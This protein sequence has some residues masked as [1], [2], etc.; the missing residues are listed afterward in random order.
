MI[1]LLRRRPGPR[2]GQA[3][4][5]YDL[6]R[7][8]CPTVCADGIAGGNRSQYTIEVLEMSE[9][10]YRPVNPDKPPYRIPPMAEIEAVPW[11]GYK[12][13]STFSGCG[14]SCLGYRWAGFR[15]VWASEF[16]EAACD[17]Y[18]LNYPDVPVDPRDIREVR[19][20]EIF[21]AT[22]LEVGEI[23][24]LEGSPPCA[25]FSTAGKKEKLWGQ[26]RPY[27]ETK[28]RTDDLFFEFI[29]L[30]EGLKPRVF[31]AENVS[32]L[33]KGTAKGYFLEILAGLKACGYRVSA[34]LLDAQWLGVPQTRQRLIFMGV[35]EDLGLEPCFPKPFQYRYSVAEACPWVVG[36]RAGG[37]EETYIPPTEPAP[38]ILSK[39]EHSET[40]RCSGTFE[41][42]E[43]ITDRPC[44][45]VRATCQNLWM[46]GMPPIEPEAFIGKYAIGKEWDHLQPGQKSDKYLNLVRPHPDE[47]CPTVTAATG[48]SLGA[49]CVTHPTE[50]RKFS[51][52]ELKRICGFPDDFRMVGSY[53]QR[54]E[55][56]GRAVPPPMMHQ[57]ALKVLEVLRE[58]DGRKA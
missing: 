8:P 49:A 30:L 15:T 3:P 41:P 31:T 40:A 39:P 17:V 4:M 56:L 58:V 29:R 20:E 57:V 33:V 45:T 47:P 46:E 50:K 19:P 13:V 34:K 48:S 2:K 16:I 36:I 28:Q 38:T 26:E 27:S 43:D 10:V 32:G 55:R 14:G 21:Q 11:N 53:S 7:E 23:D 42:R 25:S 6:V 5:A 18:A 1:V 37:V 24:V 52:G 35:R 51:I 9:P 22:G 44:P 12:L 54:W